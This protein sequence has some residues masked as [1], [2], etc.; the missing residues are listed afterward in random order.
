MKVQNS[1]TQIKTDLIS[2]LTG[3]VDL[4]YPPQCLICGRGLQQDEAE[5]CTACLS[6]FKLLG[7]PHTRFS[8]PGK[9][10][11]TTAWPLFDFDPAF[12]TLIHHLKYSRRR[13]PVLR[14]LD[15]FRTEILTQLPAAG[16]DLVIS[17]PLHPLKLRERGYNQVDDMSK[18]IAEQMGATLGNHLVKRSKYTQSQTKL[19]ANERFENVHEAFRLK[20]KTEVSGTHILL[21]DDVLTTGATANALSRVLQEAGATQIDLITLSTPQY[22]NP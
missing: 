17:I 7:K 14:V 1:F 8:V 9:I 11:I 15:R 10:Y 19:S 13:K 21:V 5:I 16:F 22:G 6:N 2:M 12:Q 4:V 3:V 20:G 18:W